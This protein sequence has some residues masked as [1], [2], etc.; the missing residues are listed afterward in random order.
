MMGGATSSLEDDEPFSITELDLEAMYGMATNSVCTCGSGRIRCAEPDHLKALDRLTAITSKL[1]RAAEAIRLAQWYVDLAP[2]HAQGYLRLAKAVMAKAAPKSMDIRSKDDIKKD[3]ERARFAARCLYTHGLHNVRKHGNESDDMLRLLRRCIRQYSHGDYLPDLP[4]ETVEGIFQNL[5]MN[6]ILACRRV[7]KRWALVMRRVRLCPSQIRF[8]GDKE[9]S[10]KGLQNLLRQFPGLQT[11]HLAIIYPN[12]VNAAKSAQFVTAALRHFQSTESLELHMWNFESESSGGNAGPR[13]T[14]THDSGKI[15]IQASLG[16]PPLPSLPAVSKCRR[17]V[18]HNTRGHESSPASFILVWASQS[19]ESLTLDGAFFTSDFGFQLPRLRHLQITGSTWCSRRTEFGFTRQILTSSMQIEQLYLDNIAFYASRSRE[20][21]LVE[22]LE[23]NLQNLHT[24]VIGSN[25]TLHLQDRTNYPGAFLAF[26]RLPPGMRCIDI[27]SD[28]ETLAYPFLFGGHYNYRHS[29]LSLDDFRPFE[30]LEYFRCLGP[31]H[32]PE[33]IFQLIGP[34]LSGSN[35]RLAHLELNA[36]NIPV[37]FLD[38]KMSSMRVPYPERLRTIGLHLF[39]WSSLA[40]MGGGSS[41]SMLR[42]RVF[43]DWVALFPNIETVCM[44]PAWSLQNWSYDG[45][46]GGRLVVALV[47]QTIR[48][49]EADAK[50][51]GSSEP[52]SIIKHLRLRKIY[53]TTLHGAT[54]DLAKKLIGNRPIQI[55][56]TSLRPPV[57]PWPDR[58]E[59]DRDSGTAEL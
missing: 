1:G 57:F 36:Q 37:Q 38:N 35:G 10:T 25:C 21:D 48:K 24:L 31:V 15:T 9:H 29:A 40:G 26:P 3:G 6:D 49:A 54:R 5:S 30:Y 12:S 4:V 32:H 55:H 41:S 18:L 14:V 23:E 7:S 52:E 50:A 22:T 44:N 11:G 43:I 20:D 45:G 59:E 16:P 13:S 27:L 33:H 28:M 17:L 56:N 58:V 39:N 34:S 19:L 8:A 51:E 47:E 42:D 2:Q 53:Q 46:E